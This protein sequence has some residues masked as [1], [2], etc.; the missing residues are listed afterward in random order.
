MNMNVNNPF[1]LTAVP[2]D[3]H[4]VILDHSYLSSTVSIFCLRV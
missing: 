3:K 1:H 2:G 4:R